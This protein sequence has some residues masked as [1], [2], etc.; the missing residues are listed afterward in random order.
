MRTLLVPLLAGLVMA[1]CDGTV[2]STDGR[3]DVEDATNDMTGADGVEAC[4]HFPAGVFCH[5]GELVQCRGAGVLELVR[6][7]PAG[8]QDTTD[9]PRCRCADD[10]DCPDGLT[11]V[12]EG[13]LRGTCALG[14]CT[15]LERWCDTGSLYECSADGTSAT[16]LGDCPEPCAPAG[17]VTCRARDNAI[18]ECDGEGFVSATIPC[19]A[20]TC[21]DGECRCAR[22]EDCGDGRFCTALGACRDWECEPGERFCRGQ[23]VT[24]CD[25]RG[26]S[27][28][29][30]RL[31]PP[32]AAC[33]DGECTCEDAGDCA[34]GE[35]CTEGICHCSSGIHCGEDGRCCTGGTACIALEVCDGGVCESAERCLQPCLE[36]DRCGL[37]G[38][39]CCGDDTPVCDPRNVCVP[40]CG[41]GRA[42]C[43]EGL[44]VCC[45]AGEICLFDV[46]RDPGPPCV[47]FSDCDWGEYCEPSLGRCLPDDFP[48]WVDCRVPID[49][50]GFEPETLW[51]WDGVVVAGRLHVNVAMTPVVADLNGDG[52]PDVAVNAYPT[53]SSTMHL[54]VVIDGATGQTLYFNATRWAQQWSQLAL[55]DI[56]GDGLPEI[57]MAGGTGVGV[58]RNIVDCPDPTADPQGCYLWWVALSGVGDWAHP[59]VADMRGDG[60]VQVI[61]RN[62]IYDGLTGTLI[63]S[64][65]GTGYDYAVVADITGDG[66]QELLRHQGLSAFNEAGTALVSLWSNTSLPSAGIRFAAVGDVASAGGR[67]GLPEFVITGNGS[68][69]VVAAESG[70]IVRTFAVPGGG[71]G[72]APIIADF[73]GDGRA[74]FGIAGEGCY[75]VFDLDCLGPAGEDLDGCIRPVIPPCTPGVDCFDVQ[76]CPAVPGGTGNGI[77]WSV[78]VQD[79][80]SSRTGSSVFDFEGDGR[81]E[82]VYNDECLLLV[83]DGQTGRR[84][85]R[86]VN[87]SRTAG[88][89][90]LIVDVNGDSRTNIVVAANNDQ[91]TRDCDREMGQRPPSG[92]RI[93]RPDRFPECFEADP[94][95]YCLVGTTGVFAFQDPQD[96]WVRT[97]RIWNQFNYHIDNVT[98]DARAPMA[99]VMPWETHNTFR[100]N[101]QGENP[102]NSPNPTLLSFTAS[103]AFCPPL[104]A[105]NLV[106]GNLGTQGIPAGLP[107]SV[108]RTDTLPVERVATL[109]TTEPIF[110]GGAVALRTQ[111]LVDASKVSE[112]LSFMAVA[113]DDGSGSGPSADCD[114]GSAVAT[115]EG[116]PC[117][118]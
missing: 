97:R 68:V 112:S 30:V 6:A 23:T 84:L 37:L 71:L 36:G 89:Y 21:V 100:A 54:P 63:T 42:L 87:T 106:V 28:G 81:N 96:R 31:C 10:R 118:D 56:T 65:T 86:R 75:T 116:V 35:L 117:A 69:Y 113:N 16:R 46:C 29:S 50:E 8:C 32:G 25:D 85:F 55:V 9:G 73:D 24:V 61:L 78:A 115:V 101:R 91:F 15:P 109:W 103:V 57:V 34:T 44:D 48:E 102:A 3:R 20:L 49:F 14:A 82:V 47:T 92:A 94:P 1:A 90:P 104:V 17:A 52:T 110:P 45:A 41:A 76:A 58:I 11:C 67:H 13:D 64:A 88:E 5:E 62:R 12:E 108:Y 2:L 114:P 111:Y 4:G 80:S 43:G 77:L 105:L 98:D 83:L 60:T 27:A 72:G 79:I 40:S 26:A 107:V 19:G 53:G 59:M 22:D 70:T 38:D 39:V 95:E 93:H 99:P 51:H 74:E 18:V 7:C 33:H 66:R